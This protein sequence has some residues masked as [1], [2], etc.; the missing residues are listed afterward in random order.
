MELIV[1][2]LLILG[3]VA[4]FP[5][6]F[7]ALAK[8]DIFF[9]LLTSNEI[10]FVVQSDGSLDRIIHD[11]KGYWYDTEHHEFKKDD[12][13]PTKRKKNKTFLQ[14]KYGLYWVGIPP[15]KKIYEFP[16]VKQRE[17]EGKTGDSSQWLS[18]EEKET[19]KS[20][21]FTFPRP[22]VLLTAELKD[23]TT[24]DMFILCKFEVV[25]PYEPV[26]IFKGDFFRNAG[27]ILQ[28]A[29]IDI[30]KE[31]EIEKFVNVPKGE[32]D[33]ILS[34]LKE[35]DGPLNQ[36]LIRQV[37]LRLVGITIA[38]YDPS[39]EEV[40]KAIRAKA[41]ADQRGQA[42]VVKAQKEAEA[43]KAQAEGEKIALK[44][45]A[46]G[47]GEFIRATVTALTLPGSDPTAV[48]QSASKVLASEA[49]SGKDSKVTTWV[50]GSNASVVVPPEKQ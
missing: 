29:V 16:I 6:L 13:D 3:I 46:E 15:F 43:R 19:V 14:R 39:D 26:F 48:T 2:L 23:R 25:K 47:R 27:A 32:V 42:D 24:V 9:T 28:G 44:S 17:K 45:L 35:Y 8:Y 37:G 1:N 18:K 21:R 38:K 34:P 7:F 22:F 31:H 41:L 30:I 11:V 50:D 10:K 49:V 36:E 20:L 40:V 12:P 5:F 4:T 33:G